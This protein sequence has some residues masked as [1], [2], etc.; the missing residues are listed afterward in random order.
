MALV[1]ASSVAYMTATTAIA[2]LRS[3]PQMMGRVIALQTVL[4]IGTTPIGGPLL[5]LLSDVAGG[6][7]PVLIGGVAALGA[8]ALG[9]V[10]GRRQLRRASR[11]DDIVPTESAAPT[12]ASPE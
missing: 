2:Q 1:G 10:A 9:L 11:M 5:G 7:S 4:M 6:R 3:D 12:A 8:S